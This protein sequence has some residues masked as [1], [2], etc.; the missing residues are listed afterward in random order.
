M[1][2]AGLWD[3]V[4]YVIAFLLPECHSVA[5]IDKHAAMKARKR[6]F[7]LIQSLLRIAT[8]RCLL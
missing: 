4:T 2:L 3:S 1:C 7:I 6:P 8:N 5:D